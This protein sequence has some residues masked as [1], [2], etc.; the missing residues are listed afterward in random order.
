[1]NIQ[2]R[3]IAVVGSTRVSFR[4]QLPLHAQ[5]RFRLGRTI[6]KEACK[7]YR[8]SNLKD[9][10]QRPLFLFVGNNSYMRE[11]IHIL[12]CR[13]I[14]NTMRCLRKPMQS[15]SIIDD[16]LYFY[17][18]LFR[19]NCSLGPGHYMERKRPAHDLQSCSPL[20]VFKTCWQQRF[21]KPG[22]TSVHQDPSLFCRIRPS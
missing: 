16:G 11:Q 7:G 17:Y 9:V 8:T 2:Q 19:T 4:P 22:F 14:V 13:R 20:C 3:E 1:M 21:R 6:F 5:S 18:T 10:N 15:H 12:F